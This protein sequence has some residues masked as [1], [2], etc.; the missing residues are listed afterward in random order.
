MTP[1]SHHPAPRPGVFPGSKFCINKIAIDINSAT[2]IH[3]AKHIESFENEEVTDSSG[4]LSLVFFHQGLHDRNVSH[5][6]RY[7][8]WQNPPRLDRSLERSLGHAMRGL[9]RGLAVLEFITRKRGATF[10]EV[11]AATGLP[12]AAVHRILAAL[13]EQ[14]YVWR[15]VAEGKYYA[16]GLL[17]VSTK[18]AQ[19][20]ALMCAAHNPLRQLVEQVRW[21]S[22]LFVRDGT[23][24][25]LIDTTQ[26]ASPYALRTSKIGAR[27]PILLSAVGHAALAEMLEQDR[28]K[29]YEELQ[30]SG[31]WRR[32][33][34]L[35]D[36]PPAEIIADVQKRGFAVRDQNIRHGHLESPGVHAVAASVV[37][38]SNVVGAV[39]IRWQSGEAASAL[40]SHLA[41]A[42]KSATSAIVAG[43]EAVLFIGVSSESRFWK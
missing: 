13:A 30:R 16:S 8:H 2:L 11:R 32:Q 36:K 18:G 7:A 43:L 26:S 22:D 14:G 41:D 31:E 24:M 17:A 39:R 1:Q 33:L 20:H 28:E 6:A 37:L 10:T 29:L 9:S 25:V 38:R 40:P 19:S 21:P 23:E 34:R 5:G 27:V 4:F 12:K 35:C 3:I 42:L 15:G